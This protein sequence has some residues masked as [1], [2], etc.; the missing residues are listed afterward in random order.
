MHN[1][2][3]LWQHKA[4]IKLHQAFWPDVL[5]FK[6]SQLSCYKEAQQDWIQN[7]LDNNPQLKS[8][9]SQLK[10]L[11]LACATDELSQHLYNQGFD[12]WG[13]DISQYDKQNS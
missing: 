5:F 1:L 12:T 13:G 11:E 7:I 8:E 10:V 2:V 3:W 6:L 4:Y 9:V